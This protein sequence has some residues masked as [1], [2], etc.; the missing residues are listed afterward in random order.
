MTFEYIEDTMKNQTT[1]LFK[2][3]FS[4]KDK[5]NNHNQNAT[6]DFKR[7]SEIMH[8][9][10]LDLSIE[11][12]EEIHQLFEIIKSYELSGRMDEV[13]RVWEKILT[14]IDLKTTEK[15]YKQFKDNIGLSQYDMS[16]HVKQTIK[17]LY[18]KTDS[19]SLSGRVGEAKRSWRLLMDLLEQFIPQF[20]PLPLN[21][22]DGAIPPF[23]KFIQ[24]GF[25]QY[26][27]DKSLE[28]YFSSI[29]INFIGTLYEESKMY[30]E[31]GQQDRGDEVWLEME[32]IINDRIS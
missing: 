13:A 30:Y 11:D 25:E 19:Y 8:I 10:E 28:V 18:I 14:L 23:P 16:D 29:E 27:T 24:S 32:E 9:N 6:I 20:T 31:I 15:N 3:F 26:K 21:L 1:L 7:F 22:F 5:K 12:K 4:S 2:L 17:A